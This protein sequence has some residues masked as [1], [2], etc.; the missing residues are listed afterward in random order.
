VAAVVVLREAPHL[1]IPVVLV[2]VVDGLVMVVLEILHHR[3]QHQ[4][5]DLQAEMHLHLL[6]LHMQMLVEVE[7]EVEQVLLV[8]IFPLLLQLAEQRDLVVLDHHLLLQDHQ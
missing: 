7:V 3:H 8:E 6:F 2:V 5:K 1:V 4:H